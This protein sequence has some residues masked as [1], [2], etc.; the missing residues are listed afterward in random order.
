MVRKPTSTVVLSDLVITPIEK[1]VE[2]PACLGEY[3]GCS[4]EFCVEFIERCKEISE[5]KEKCP[6]ST[7]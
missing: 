2:T 4:G 6:T 3:E 5:E 7:G 1:P